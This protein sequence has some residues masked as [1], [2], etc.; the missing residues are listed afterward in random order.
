MHTILRLEGANCSSCFNDVLDSLRQA[1]G[2]QRVDGSMVG[3][4]IEIDHSDDLGV[5]ELV[6]IVRPHA[7]GIAMYANEIEMIPLE[8]TPTSTSCQHRR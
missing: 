6:A 1:S 4:S 3:S 8:P 2:V 5:C 7:H